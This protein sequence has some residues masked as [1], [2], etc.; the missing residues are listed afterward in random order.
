M[1]RVLCWLLAAQAVTGCASLPGHMEEPRRDFPRFL[2]DD[3]PLLLVEE[4]RWDAPLRNP[5]PPAYGMGMPGGCVVKGEFHV[6]IERMAYDRAAG[7]LRL[8]GRLLR[9]RGS[10]NVL[11]A[12]LDWKEAGEPRHTVTRSSSTF[13]LDLDV[14]HN[15]TLTLSSPGFRT[16]VLDLRILSRRAARTALPG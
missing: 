13:S 16:L 6:A 10:G 11:V 14:K 4:E 12:L 7:R 2:V 9:S 8:E 5:R 3:H 1:R 15:R